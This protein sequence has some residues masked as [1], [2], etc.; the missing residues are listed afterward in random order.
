VPPFSCADANADGLVDLSDPIFLLA[1]LFQG[2]EDPLVIDNL[3]VRTE[4]TSCYNNTAVLQSCPEQSAEFGG[5][6]GFYQSGYSLLQ[7]GHTNPCTDRFVVDD[8]GDDDTVTDRATGLM[9]TKAPVPRPTIPQ[10]ERVCQEGLIGELPMDMQ[11]VQVALNELNSS[12]FAG[13]DDWR[14]PTAYELLS[15]AHYQLSNFALDADIFDSAG[16]TARYWSSNFI[17]DGTISS[18]FVYCNYS[19][20]HLNVFDGCDQNEAL[21]AVRNVK[22]LAHPNSQLLARYPF[23]Y[24]EANA[25]GTADISDA[26][27][28]LGW[29]FQGTG[30][31]PCNVIS[32]VS[33][34]HVPSGVTRFQVDQNT[35]TDRLTGLTW[36]KVAGVDLMVW[37]DAL[38]EAE[39]ETALGGKSDWRLPNVLE[40]STLLRWDAA[41]GPFFPAGF[42]A[43]LEDSQQPPQPLAP[44]FWTSTT[45]ATANSTPKRAWKVHFNNDAAQLHDLSFANGKAPNLGVTHDPA[46]VWMV[47]GG[48]GVP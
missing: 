30:A 11:H 9:W 45:A 39:S 15:I 18:S 25:D 3:L 36:A 8:A 24:G 12:E 4:Q 37:E 44:V 16:G 31:E 41:N 26:V 13:F 10:Q 42:T 17:G 7:Y 32:P 6:D 46:R 23:T 38:E 5:Q 19:S 33:P 1:F 43:A 22:E 2:G 47:R 34:Q 48:Q 28:I 29:L 40:L 21:R 35:V 20:G 27:Y 14:L